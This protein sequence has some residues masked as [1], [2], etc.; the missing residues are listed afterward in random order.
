MP[1]T[2]QLSERGLKDFSSFGGD[3]GRAYDFPGGF[4]DQAVGPANI[5][6]TAW[7]GSAIGHNSVSN[8][9]VG[10]LATHGDGGTINSDSASGTNRNTARTITFSTISPSGE[11]RVK[12]FGVIYYRHV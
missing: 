8:D 2:R 7:T 9:S 11:N 12:N 5:R 6:T 4:Q 3:S 10:F 1:D